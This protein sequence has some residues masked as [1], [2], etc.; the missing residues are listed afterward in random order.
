MTRQI[1]LQP[2]YVLHQRA[3]RN[4]SALL[5]V[6]TRDHGRIGVIAK[7]IKGKGGES[8]R[9]ILQPFIHLLISYSGRQDLHTLIAAES[10]GDTARLS[11]QTIFSAF[12]LNELLMR[13]LHRGEAHEQLFHGYDEAINRLKREEEC[14][15]VLRRFEMRLL[16]ELGYGLQLEADALNQAPIDT[17]GR[18]YYDPAQGPVPAHAMKTAWPTVSG[19]CLR[20]LAQGDFSDQRYWPE[21]KVVMRSV[22]AHHLEGRPLR[23][24]EL[25]NMD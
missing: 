17:G 9:G 7:G 13:L 16:Q 23:S 1:L 21:M 24:R 12:Y 19:G 10:P 22:I 14:E 4:T 5:E 25:F 20:A 2:A 11:G 3:Y 15:P 6:L 8:R 18:Y